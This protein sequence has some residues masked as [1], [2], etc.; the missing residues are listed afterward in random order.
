M[1]QWKRGS[2]VALA[3]CGLMSGVATAG[4]VFDAI[5]PFRDAERR[6]VDPALL[7]WGHQLLEIEFPYTW[8]E[9]LE[10]LEKAYPYAGRSRLETWLKYGAEFIM[11][12]GEPR[13][14]SAVV[15]SFAHRH[16]DIMRRKNQEEGRAAEKFAA[17]LRSMAFSGPE[18]SYPAST[19]Q[20][21]INPITY[22]GTQTLRIPR[23]ALSADGTLKLWFPLPIATGDQDAVRVLS[24][25]P[26]RWVRGLPTVNEELGQLY[27]EVPLQELSGDL[28]VRLT[29]TF[30]HWERRSVVNPAQVG[31]YDVASELYRR[32]TAPGIHT[33]LTRE[34]VDKAREIVGDEK[35]PWVA[36]RKIYDYMLKHVRYSFTPHLSLGFTGTPEALYVLRN[37]FGDCG[38]QSML[39]SALCRAVGIPARTTGGYQMV[40]RHGGTHFWAEFYL[41]AYGWIPVDV[42]MADTASWADIPDEERISFEN[43]CFGNMDPFRM[44]IQTDVEIPLQPRPESPVLLMAPSGVPMVFQT[45]ALVAPHFA[46]T[47]MEL[48]SD[49]CEKYWTQDVVPL[50]H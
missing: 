3:L 5:T 31:T 49:L 1:R 9:A 24:V 2:L 12:D 7:S 28:D 36:A 10:I 23:S 14:F 32:Y 29:F 39:F 45:P 34:I 20:P 37:G 8:S 43:Y 40:P 38:A 46:V 6:G 35:N 48:V 15:N 25:T 11:I 42:T 13:Y 50:D 19:F 21:F 16:D 22:L 30:C 44:V 41:P 4:P 47:P 27:M 26:E 17:P 18:E 33:P